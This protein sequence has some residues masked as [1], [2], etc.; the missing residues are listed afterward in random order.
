MNN[1]SND[2]NTINKDVNSTTLTLSSDEIIERDKIVL[3]LKRLG[4]LH[5]KDFLEEMLD[6]YNCVGT[7]CLTSGQ[8]KGFYNR[9]MKQIYDE[10][11]KERE[12]K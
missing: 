1:N 8:V 4:E 10:K 7:R 11:M 2:A 12:N 3:E 6:E 9:K 5:N